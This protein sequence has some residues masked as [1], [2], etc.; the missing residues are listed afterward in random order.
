M[1]IYEEVSVW[2]IGQ[3]KT[4]MCLIN[5]CLTFLLNFWQCVKMQTLCF[6]NEPGRLSIWVCVNPEQRPY[7]NNGT[8]LDACALLPL[9]DW[10]CLPCSPECLLQNFPPMDSL[11]AFRLIVWCHLHW[12]SS[13]SLMSPHSLSRPLI[14]SIWDLHYG[15]ILFICCFMLS[16]LIII[17]ILIL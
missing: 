14:C 5:S 11:I 6:Q 9:H 16:Y 10:M 7:W 12:L 1:S 4:T 13:Q 8:A 3:D 15:I 17:S 2:H